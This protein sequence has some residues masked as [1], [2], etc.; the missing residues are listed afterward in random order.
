MSMTMRSRKRWAGWL[1][2]FVVA[3]VVAYFVHAELKRQSEP[4]QIP[5][6]HPAHVQLAVP[7]TSSVRSLTMNMNAPVPPGGLH[8]MYPDTAAHREDISNVMSWLRTAV[9]LGYETNHPIPTIGPM[10]VEIQLSDHQTLEV[11][12]ALNVTESKRGG[13]TQYVMVAS[14]QDVVVSNPA[15][16]TRAVEV[17]APQLALWL[18]GGWRHSFGLK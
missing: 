10:A 4:R 8:V 15:D 17:R 13:A 1:I 14:S 9:P 7:L 18:R 5:S 6:Y 2:A 11:E 12:Q 3:A 16:G